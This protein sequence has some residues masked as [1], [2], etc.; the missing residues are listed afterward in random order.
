MRSCFSAALVCLAVL[1]AQAE[2]VAALPVGA[3]AFSV[4]FEGHAALSDK[5]LRE[6]TRR[7]EFEIYSLYLYEEIRDAVED[8]YVERGYPSAV[9]SATD[10]P[11]P[12]GRAIALHIEEGRHFKIGQVHVTG[13]ETFSEEELR[14]ILI[15]RPGWFSDPDFDRVRIGEDRRRI[16]DFYQARGF[17][18]AQ[19]TGGEEL[20]EKTGKAV[21]M[22]RVSEGPR[23]HLAEVQFTGNQVYSASEA[24]EY[25]KLVAGDAYNPLEA[26]AARARLQDQYRNH[27]F[28][29]A[30]VDANVRIDHEAHLVAAGFDVRE[31]T[32]V[33]I[34]D[35][36][37]TGN[38][39]TKDRV[40]MR[41]VEL[42][43]G[44]PYS[45]S[46]LFDTRGNIFGLGLFNSVSVEPA[47]PLVG[48]PTTDLVLHVEEGKFARLRT[49]VGYGT[50]T[51]S[52]TSAEISYANL[53]GL[54]HTVGVFA[55]YTGIGDQER[56]YYVVPRAFGSEYEMNA[57]VYHTVTEEPSYTVERL[58][59]GITFERHYRDFWTVRWRYS[60]EDL[61]LS[62]VDVLPTLAE[63]RESEGILSRLGLVLIRDTRNNTL[64]PH[65]GTYLRTDFDLAGGVLFGDFSFL[66]A[67]ASGGWFLPVTRRSTVA[68]FGRAGWTGPYGQSGVTPLGERFLLGGSDTLRGFER[69]KVGPRDS[70]GEYIGGDT[71]MNF[72]A[73]YRF[74][75]YKSLGGAFFYD[76]GN[77]WEDLGGVDVGNLRHDAG[78]GL[79]YVSPIATMRVDWARVL[80]AEEYEED[81]RIDFSIGRAF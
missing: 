49:G 56:A 46:D 14:D 10:D 66:R 3:T 8:L 68:L 81:S 29:Y 38:R 9:V 22:H 55:E 75:V 76:A 44:E 48:Q 45:R 61:T 18:R 13:N 67:R 71:M 28:A 1:C 24:L 43:P 5:A 79:R 36:T 52:R 21:V 15:M 57:E 65:E 77:V 69:D 33:V 25:S 70:S 17:L 2:E 26:E 72:T 12:R 7:P 37:L 62:N 39:K 6:V 23:Y 40:I 41:E 64:D 78:V 59:A 11:T 54:A 53:F 20:V 4:S 80:D 47:S 27:G 19:A 51:G 58:G 32:R 35:V 60:L 73:E 30:E 63:F 50:L 74:P 16:E 34:R 31:G 42:E